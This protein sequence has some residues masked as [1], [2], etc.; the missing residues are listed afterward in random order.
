MSTSTPRPGAL[1]TGLRLAVVGALLAL[2]LGVVPAASAA[3]L[4]RF[5]S[6][7]AAVSGTW[8]NP[9]NVSADDGA[10]ATTNVARNSSAARDF[11]SFGFDSIPVGATITSATLEI[12]FRVG[13]NA[14]TG[15]VSAQARVSGADSGTA[16]SSSAQPT[17]DT[18]ISSSN[19]GISSRSQLLDGTFA[20]RFTTSRGGTGT[21]GSVTT[22]VDFVRVTVVY[23]VPDTT[24]PVV[25]VPADIT[26]EA[27]GPGGAVVTYTATA[28]DDV[29]GAL[30]PVCTNPSGS[31]FS[32]GTTTVTCVAT[33]AAGNTGQATF[34]VTVVDTTPPAVTVP[35]NETAEATGSTGASV[36]YGAATATDLVSGSLAA[37][38]APASGSTFP[39]G[40]T[41]V[42]C[43][44]T[45]AAGN[46]GSGSFSVTV[47]DTTPPAVTVPANVTTAATSPAGATVAYGAASATD[48]VDGALTPAC[49]PASGSTF[50]VG[51]TTVT[52]S[53]T[54]AAGNTGSNT[55]TVTV[56]PYVDQ[57]PT[58]DLPADITA[59]AT[60]AAG[61]VV[62]YSATA[63][64]LEDGALVPTC[65][66]ASGSTFAL[67]ATTVDC[68]VTDSAS[69]TT[70]GSFSVTV[71]DTTPPAVTVP[72][73]VT[74]AATS[75][76]GATVAYGAASATD[77]VDG[78]LTPAC[79]PA[80]GSLFSVG[81]T[82]VTCSATDAAGN[83]GSNTFTVTVTAYLD[84]TPPVV[85][86]PASLTVEATSAAGAV[87]TFSAS[88]TDA[89]DG[90]LTPSCSPASGS[91]FPLGTTTVTCTATDAAGNTGSGS[92]TVT[93][94][95]TTPPDVSV[96]SDITEEATGPAG[97]KVTYAASADDIVDGAVAVDCSRSSGAMFRLGTTIVTCTATDDAGNTGSASFEVAVVDTTAPDIATPPDITV[98]ASGPNGAVVTYEVAATDLVDG[99]V[100]PTCVPASG[101][102]FPIGTTTVTCS[103]SDAAG[104]STGDQ[105]P[106]AESGAYGFLVTVAPYDGAVP[107]TP[108]TAT[109]DP[110]GRASSG[111]LPFVG[112]SIAGAAG[113]FALLAA[114]GWRRRHPMA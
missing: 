10:Y 19:L 90:P 111:L 43:T 27:T 5:P 87:A 107:S 45:D 89:I 58:L 31:T 100:T 23:T 61:A 6:S 113:L 68:S 51:A 86:V 48:L 34:Y 8:T 109:S 59:E 79:A 46:T 25:T 53:A 13:N 12:Q 54:D 44:A 74:T 77:L 97:A 55:F 33:D 14:G 60:S 35:A 42:T 28:T 41:T 9:G 39:L 99:D 16:A 112:L 20:V 62:T 92:F 24:P 4:A 103:A 37:N 22:Y 114:V 105:V 69:N 106:A 64:D 15:A 110:A 11:G 76:A 84:T 3:T 91:T 40:S 93:V 71:V 38:C 80:S 67:G 47:V 94:V 101:S 70:T 95:D 72:A 36:S 50:A 57:P 65:V 7:N 88:A 82:T 96:P 52:C 29:D 63:D 2:S 98:P 32:L 75:P 56:T 83:T 17:T 81:A 85:T 108:P 66:P 104:N 102:L 1:R 18:T 49:A 78:A 73:N 21:N 30:T 26:A